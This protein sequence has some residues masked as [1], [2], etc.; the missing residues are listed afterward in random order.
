[1]T[2]L[3]RGAWLFP[4]NKCDDSTTTSLIVDLLNV[5]DEKGGVY[6]VSACTYNA[7]DRTGSLIQGV[8][9]GPRVRNRNRAVLFWGRAR[10]KDLEDE[11]NRGEKGD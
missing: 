11:R 2:I 9:T 10:V 4:L 3:N 5:G 1:M 7:V 6:W 8:P